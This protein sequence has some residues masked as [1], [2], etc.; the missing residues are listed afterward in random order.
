M[1]VAEEQKAE[2]AEV[3]QLR[4]IDAAEVEDRVGFSRWTAW[5]WEREDR[6]PKSMKIGSLRMW[7]ES[8][9]REWMEAQVAERDARGR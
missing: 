1:K 7:I 3:D 6:F 2:T 8:E 4:F 9:V 5:R